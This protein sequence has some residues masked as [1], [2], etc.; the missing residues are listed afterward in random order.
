MSQTIWRLEEQTG[1]GVFETCLQAQHGGS[2][3]VPVVALLVSEGAV[4]LQQQK[5]VRGGG[6]HATWINNTH[7]KQQLILYFNLFI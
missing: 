7:P 6:L 5:L 4:S 1:T 2:G 3:V